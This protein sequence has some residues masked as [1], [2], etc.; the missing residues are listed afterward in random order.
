MRLHDGK[1]PKT[2]LACASLN[3]CK[4]KTSTAEKGLVA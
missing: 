2:W 4:N 3:G 1:F